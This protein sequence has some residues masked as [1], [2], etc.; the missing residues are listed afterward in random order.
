MRITT[1]KGSAPDGEVWDALAILQYEGSESNDD[2][3]TEER[4]CTADNPCRVL[5]CP[6]DIYSKVIM[7]IIAD[8]QQ[9]NISAHALYA[10]YPKLI[11]FPEL[12]LLTAHAQVSMR[13]G[14]TY[15]ENKIGA[16]SISAIVKYYFKLA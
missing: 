12:L 11:S 10:N 16:N 7:T 13:R 4:N 8:R 9:R 15:S 1:V 14:N 5:N 6:W 2:P 3:T